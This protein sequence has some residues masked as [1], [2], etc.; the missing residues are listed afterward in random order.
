MRVDYRETR[1][2]VSPPHRDVLLIEMLPMFN[3]WFCSV[4]EFGNNSG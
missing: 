4:P 1:T 2:C 3:V